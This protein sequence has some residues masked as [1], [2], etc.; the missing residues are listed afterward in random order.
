MHFHFIVTDGL[1]TTIHEF[2]LRSGQVVVMGRQPECDIVLPSSSVSRRH[3][4]F[5][6]QGGSCVAEDMRSSN[7]VVVDGVRIAGSMVLPPSTTA[8]VG[9][10]RVD[11]STM[12]TEG[13]NPD[14]GLQVYAA[15]PRLVGTNTEVEGDVYD[16]TGDEISIGRTD[17]NDIQILSTA[18]SR[19]HA[20]IVRQ[21]QNQYVIVDL[22]SSNGTTVNGE[23]ARL[24]IVLQDGD[25]VRFGRLSFRFEVAGQTNARKQRIAEQRSRRPLLFAVGGAVVVVVLLLGVLVIQKNGKD[26]SSDTDTTEAAEWQIARETARAA[27]TTGDWATAV[28]Q[29][30]NALTG[31]PHDDTLRVELGAAEL[32]LE[33]QLALQSC[34]VQIQTAEGLQAAGQA[35]A[36]AEALTQAQTCLVAIPTDTQAGAAAVA[37]NSERLTP[38]LITLYRYLGAASLEGRDYAT[39]VQSFSLAAAAY[40]RHPEIERATSFS[41]QYRVA[42]I[43]AGDDA[44]GREAWAVAIERYTLA[45]TLA[46]LDETR[47]QRLGQAQEHLE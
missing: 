14:S 4:R 40:E 1:G 35:L 11:I 13:A 42:L 25:D 39:A 2:N 10:Y 7:G 28:E 24:P 23:S 41:N 8:L 33:A 26:A 22:Q 18:V 36:A 37:R 38:E 30:R 19:H 44:F 17:Q 21:D 15:P 34:D 46:P 32:E 27:A 9:D 29:L 5:T 16:I 31:N 20:R 47:Q 45:N 43:G 6:V 12:H 3:A